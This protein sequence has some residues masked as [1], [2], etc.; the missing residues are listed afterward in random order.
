MTHTV[1]LS[2]PRHTSAKNVSRIIR[3]S[4]PFPFGD[5]TQRP[6]EM[7]NHS[8][9]EWRESLMATFERENR[10]QRES[11]VDKIQRNPNLQ[12]MR[13]DEIR[14]D[15]KWINMKDMEGKRVLV[16]GVPPLLTDRTIRKLVLNKYYDFDVSGQP[17]IGIDSMTY[18]SPLTE[19]PNFVSR[20]PG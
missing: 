14:F 11:Y 17:K 12:K 15:R 9:V 13:S 19:E 2:L 5:D 10:R 20:L 1:H 16:M 18:R 8:D 6:C 7:T 3:S 4:L